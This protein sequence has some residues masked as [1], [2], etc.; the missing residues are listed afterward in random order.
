MDYIVKTPCGELQGCPGRVPGTAAYKGIRY[1]TAGR[2]EY[3]VLVTSWDGVYDA[4]Q[5]G[6]CSY[7]PRAFYNEEE[8]T[9]K[10]FYF[11]EFRRGETYT[12][13]EDCLFLNVFAPDTVGE[14]EKLP[15]LVYI[16]GGGFTGGC[17]HEK[18][19]DGPVWPAKGVVGVTLNYRLGPLGFAC[20]P[21][22]KQEAGATGNYGLYDQLAAITWVRDN[23]ASFGGDPENITIM[24]QS[25]GAMSVQQHCLSPLSAGLFQ[26]A[27][28]SS[29]GGVSKLMPATQPEK[30]YD[31]WHAVMD[32]TGCKTLEQFRALPVQTLFSTWQNLKKTV[33]GGN[34]SPCLD[35]RLV[36][37]TGTEILKAGQH[38]KIPYMAGSTSE[39]VMPPV[40]YQ[41]AKSWCA[42]QEKNSYAWFFDRRLPG[43]DN[44]AWHSSDL[45]YWFGTL[46]NCWRPMTK[47]DQELSCRMTDYLTN[48]C[49]FGDPNGAGLTAWLPMNR[50]QDKVLRLGEGDIRMGKADMLKLTK[51]MLTNKAVGE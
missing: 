15:V 26:K 33:K 46:D 7:Q 6:N 41:M 50:G 4:T 16:H 5:Y 2:W 38:R 11:N 34:C 13:S 49:K 24:G 40:I 29:G 10:A 47:K 17:G 20:L 35:G 18:H 22:L 51:T 25:A 21:E 32:A 48:F 36:V 8:V 19:F 43:D 45:W 44:G 30:S 14:G 1:A 3:P 9:E 37:G 42:A 28:M 12:Y 27:V 39:D 31:F 23:I